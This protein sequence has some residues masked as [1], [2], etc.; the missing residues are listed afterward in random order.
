MS[1]AHESNSTISRSTPAVPAAAMLPARSIS[2]SP[3]A[4]FGSPRRPVPSF[5]WIERTRPPRSP[6]IAPGSTPP[7]VAQY[8]STCHATAG[9]S[10]ASRRRWARSPSRSTTSCSWLWTPNVRPNPAARAA[11]SS[12]KSAVRSSVARLATSAATSDGVKTRSAPMA[13]TASNC[14]STGSLDPGEIPTCAP[15]MRSPE[16]SAQRRAAVGSPPGTPTVS[17]AS[18]PIAA[19][20]SK[21]AGHGNPMSR[22]EYSWTPITQAENTGAVTR[23]PGRSAPCAQRRPAGQLAGRLTRR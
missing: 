13:A 22:T 5:R 3:S 16:S 21:S 10:R 6:I 17:I 15:A 20:R 2:P 14:G 4:T 11:T 8:T 9:D 18:Y 7:H 12:R 19:N 23:S 1:V